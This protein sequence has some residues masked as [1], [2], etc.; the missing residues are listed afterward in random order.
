MSGFHIKLSVGAIVGKIVK[1]TCD[2]GRKKLLAE[3]L[4][5]FPMENVIPLFTPSGMGKHCGNSDSGSRLKALYPA[6]VKDVPF[7]PIELT[8]RA[9][10]IFFTSGR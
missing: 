6:I 1:T 8:G 4:E 5:V 3:S 10:G 2:P 7:V 9:N